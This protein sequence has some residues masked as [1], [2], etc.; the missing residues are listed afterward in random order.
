MRLTGVRVQVSLLDPR[1]YDPWGGGVQPDIIGLSYPSRETIMRNARVGRLYNMEPALRQSWYADLWRGPLETF[2][3]RGA[4]APGYGP[5]VYGV[6]LTAYV[7]AFVYN[8]AIFRRAGVTPPRTWGD[9]LAASS[10]LRRIGV[11]PMAGGMDG[12]YPSFPVIYEWSYLGSFY[13]LETYY[14]RYPYT[15]E[16]W[17]RDFVLYDEMHRY[18]VTTL[19]ASGMDRDA[20]ERRFLAGE[21]A[22]MLDGPWFATVQ[23]SRSPK[24]TDWGVFGP[25]VDPRASFLPRFPGG[26]AEGAVVNSMSRNKDAAIRFLR[27]L[28]E[29]GQQV[30]LANAMD[31]LPGSIAAANSTRLH[32]RL[33]AFAPYLSYAAVELR[34]RAKPGVLRKLYQ[35]AGQVIG[36]RTTPAQALIAA[37]R[38]V[39]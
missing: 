3:L 22:M 8:K 28:T 23:Q 9:L 6:P 39:K 27:W 7:R 37:Q 34:Y 19:G 36:G 29:P 35:G 18:G 20:T 25:P 5:G 32:G 12:L 13:L 2:E 26:V 21:F 33:R 17:R 10:K 14:G 4:D 1:R 24:F 16:R 31:S 30:R 15:G 38:A 11:L